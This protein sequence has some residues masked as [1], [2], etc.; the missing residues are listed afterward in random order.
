MWSK[1]SAA[2]VASS[3]KKVCRDSELL[4]AKAVFLHL[5]T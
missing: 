5:K 2:V 3:S 1:I 4:Y